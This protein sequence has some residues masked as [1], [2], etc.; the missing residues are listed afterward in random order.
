[1]HPHIPLIN[2]VVGK[3]TQD[4]AKVLMIISDRIT[5][6]SQ[7]DLEWIANKS[8]KLQKI[9]DCCEEGPLLVAAKANF[10]P[11]SLSA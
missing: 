4:K 6:L 3:I 10:P 8:V 1:M 5:L 9:K 7:V 2:R 11:G